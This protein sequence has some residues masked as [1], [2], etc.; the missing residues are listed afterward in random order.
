MVN[1]LI[2]YQFCMT[3]I[4]LYEFFEVNV[5]RD[6]HEAH[7]LLLKIFSGVNHIPV[8]SNNE[9]TDNLLPNFMD[10]FFYGLYK[11]QFICSSCQENNIYFE[12]FH[13]ILVLPNVDI[14]TYFQKETYEEKCITCSKCA[15]QSNQSLCITLHEKPN[16]LLIQVNRLNNR[17]RK[18]NQLF[19][20]HED[21]KLGLVKYKLLGFITHQGV[22][23]NSGHYVNWVRYSNKRYH[24]NDHIIKD[25][26]LLTSSKE[27]YL[28]F[29]IKNRLI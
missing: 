21:I 6:V 4:I 27:V 25:Y 11:V 13:H 5:L 10:S 16:V 18:N 1:C 29:Y 8:P 19:G 15:V 3:L 24:C 28:L 7:L 12:T 2:L 22:F 26:P 23:T 14:S 17:P 9:I 20:I